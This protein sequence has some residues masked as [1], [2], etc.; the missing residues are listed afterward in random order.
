MIG[1]RIPRD[2]RSVSMNE[3]DRGMLVQRHRGEEGLERPGRQRAG[4]QSKEIAV[5]RRDL[6]RKH[7]RPAIDELARNQFEH[8]WLVGRAR[9]EG[10]EVASVRDRPIRCRPLLR[11]VEELAFRR[12]DIHA[13]QFARTGHFRRQHPVDGRRGDHPCK[14]IRHADTVQF[15]L[16]GRRPHHFGEITEHVL[17]VPG[18][19]VGVV[20]KLAPR[21]RN[22][23]IARSENG[24]RRRRRDGRDQDDA[25]QR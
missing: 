3:R 2:Q 6:L 1:L 13:D 10:V 21:G 25:A 17:V 15:D 18:D 22:R 24:N 12:P 4:D 9:L 20:L 11:C 16:G 5:R 8:E 23:A 19:K 7:Q 14:G